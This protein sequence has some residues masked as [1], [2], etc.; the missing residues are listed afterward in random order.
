MFTFLDYL[1]STRTLKTRAK[2]LFVDRARTET[3]SNI[4]ATATKLVIIATTATKLIA[5]TETKLVIATP[6]TT[7]IL[8]A[9][10]TSK[11]ESS[12]F[13]AFL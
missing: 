9:R 2:K 1:F 13:F 12:K 4:A 6:E 10:T 7:E 8:I 5:T 3:T 11:S